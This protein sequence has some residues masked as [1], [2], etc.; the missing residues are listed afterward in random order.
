MIITDQPVKCGRCHRVLRS[1][2]S[3][4]EGY[5]PGCKAIMRAAAIA[6]AVKGFAAAQVEKARELIEDRALVATSRPGVFR[7]VSSD[8]ERS[9][10]A[11]SET[12]N[13]P[14]GLRR[15][16]ACTCKHSL[17]VRIRLAA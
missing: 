11:H 2:R 10:L 16:T 17:A 14:S 4:R 13:C 8:G 1:A 12:C 3:V 6:A 9:Y 7:V 15:L 5:G